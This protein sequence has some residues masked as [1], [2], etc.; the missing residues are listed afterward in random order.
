MTVVARFL[1]L[2]ESTSRKQLIRKFKDVNAINELLRRPFFNFVQTDV[3]LPLPLAF[4]DCGDSD[5]LARARQATELA[6]HILQNLD[7]A[8]P[9]HKNDFTLAEFMNHAEASL[10]ETR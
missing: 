1:N 9:E 3:Y 8:Y 6:L 10:M 4:Q 5:F 7:E 2:R